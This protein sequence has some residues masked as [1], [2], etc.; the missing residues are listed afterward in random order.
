MIQLINDDFDT[1]EP[2][3]TEMD[4]IYSELDENS[5]IDFLEEQIL[6]IYPSDAYSRDYLTEYDDEYSIIMDKYE[7]NDEIEESLKSCKLRLYEKVL[8]FL[9]TKFTFETSNFEY[10][11]EEDYFTIVKDLY[12]FFIINRRH[13]IE[14]F[15]TNYI[16]INRKMIIKQIKENIPKNNDTSSTFR[17]YGAEEARLI[18][19]LDY[20]IDD[21][22]QSEPISD[23]YFIE[24]LQTTNMSYYLEKIKTYI[25]N[26]ELDFN[27][28]LFLEYISPL[29]DNNLYSNMLRSAIFQET[30]NEFK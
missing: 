24:V 1:Y 28:N 27:G 5:L 7:G 11:N 13:L 23:E 30:V 2:N 14:E 16:I 4:F 17:K 9:K 20:I 18:A 21:L 12:K 6:S 22:L 3:Q 29:F 19:N 8:E 26:M 10:M 25:I 15:V